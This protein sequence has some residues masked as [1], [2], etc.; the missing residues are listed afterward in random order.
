[1]KNL[2][3]SKT[4]AASLD[5]DAPSVY[6][7]IAEPDSLPQWHPAFCRAV[8]REDGMLV[9]ETPRGAVPFDWV[10]NDHA[11]VI[12]LIV[13]RRD[14]PPM[15]TAIRV[16]PAGEGC[17]VTMTLVRPEGLPES[18]FQDGIRWTETALRNLRKAPAAPPRPEPTSTKDVGPSEAGAPESSAAL[19]PAPAEPLIPASNRK[20]FIGNLPYDWTEEQL[21][22]H[23]AGAGEVTA[24]AIARFRRRGGRSRGFGF[25][26]MAT[27]EQAQAAITHLH[28][29]LAGSR[30]ILVRVSKS[31][32]NRQEEKDEAPADAQPSQETSP[33]P[34][35][36]ARPRSRPPHRSRGGRSRSPSREP[37]RSRR[38]LHLESAHHDDA[39][40]IVNNSG[41]E[42]FPR[43][44]SAEKAES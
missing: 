23:F 5:Q 1:M 44:S 16:L 22:A 15:L 28:E 33:A 3:R 17:E 29:S 8:R 41:Y 42:Y 4:W 24:A 38:P 32:E 35:P 10:R 27:E 7:R 2:H 19:E 12:D 20:L 43:R 37:R 11:R 25:V 40:E 39:P 18:L 34:A 26:E 31:Q 14:A 6:A 30:K 21:R 36:A 13:K 9:A